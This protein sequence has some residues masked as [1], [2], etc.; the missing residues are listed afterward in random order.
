MDPIIALLLG[1]LVGVLLGAVI[2]LL[3]AR[4]RRAAEPAGPVAEDPALIEARHQAALAE[5]RNEES[6]RRAEL[7]AQ[8]GDLR[9][10]LAARLASAESTVTSLR[11][12]LHEQRD[13]H[14]ALSDRAETERK[15]R[16]ERE[17]AAALEQSKV[18][19]ALAPV[20][21]TL[22]TMRK[23]VTDIEEQRSL[24]HGELSQQL[25]HSLSSE[26]NLRATAESL[27]SALR[28]NSTRG[29]W[30]EVQLRR[31]V[32]AAGL[33]QHVDY[34]EQESIVS[35]VGS[36]RI[37][38]VVKLSDGKSLAIDSKVPFESFLQANEIPV[39]ATGTEAETRARLMR[40]HAKKLRGHVDDL[41]KR[42]YWAG[43]PSSPDLVIGF[44]PSE[45]LL[46]AAL[47]ADPGL[48]DHAFRK[49][50]ALASPI[51]LW[52]VLKTVAYSWRQE[53]MSNDAKRIFDLSN[54]LYSRLRTLADHSDAL[55][56][57][58]ESTI[59]HY[60]K[61]ASSLESRVLVTA[62]KIHENGDPSMQIVE[63]KAIDSAPKTLTSTYLVGDDDDAVSARS[64]AAVEAEL[65]AL[66]KPQPELLS[67]SA[68]DA[69]SGDSGEE[70]ERA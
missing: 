37:D 13:Q 61:F 2:G 11:E 48:L 16:V 33:L 20:R 40:D 10:D 63:P 53:A 25:R 67:P 23:K 14:R 66:D 21:E 27:A 42:E 3:I 55:R 59:S 19:E 57:S 43:L 38:M 12:Q 70:R 68:N 49:N 52:A 44:I 64:H 15:E 65:H 18:L 58:I 29:M 47:E 32:E 9:A 60:N 69:D 54:D 22:D 31:L 6:A 4:S 56:R 46:S 41:A 50:V 45:S 7:A 51:T 17:R 62:R 5:V 34:V 24:Q 39:T 35:D 1:L 26:E 8:Q 28:N 30:G 36:G